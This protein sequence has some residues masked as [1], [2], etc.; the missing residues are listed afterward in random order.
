MSPRAVLCVAQAG[1][2]G[3][4]ASAHAGKQG[5]F[6]EQNTSCNR[7]TLKCGASMSGM[8]SDCLVRS[9]VRKCPHNANCSTVE[10]ENPSQGLY[11]MKLFLASEPIQKAVSEGF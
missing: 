4:W 10:M 8:A 6:Q 7:A 1:V 5:D 11:G 2:L 9:S 3:T